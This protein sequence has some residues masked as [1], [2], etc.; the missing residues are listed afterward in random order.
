MRQA[1]PLPFFLILVLLAV[2]IWL[3]S[4]RLGLM[5]ALHIPVSDLALAFTP[6]T[7]AL[8]AV[9]MA[10]GRSGFVRLLVTPFRSFSSSTY[11]G[12]AAAI[13]SP[14]LLYLAAWAVAHL[15]GSPFPLPAGRVAKV[16]MLFPLFMAL[17]LGEELG[18]T[19]HALEA[20]E[21]RCGPLGASLLLALPWW[22]GHLPSMAAIGVDATGMA[23]WLLG[24]M[25]LRVLM[26]ALYHASANRL[27]VVLTFH[28]ML[29]L[30]RL[31]IFP[32][33]GAHYV[34]SYQ[35]TSY[36]LAGACALFV[37]LVT[38]GRLFCDGT[39]RGKD[40]VG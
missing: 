1:S 26:T 23:W 37:V 4:P 20:L 8:C 17:A 18:W 16:I 24:A 19:A 27:L 21:T 32:A 34:P 28:A 15:A 14:W 38:K 3:A 33:Q 36:L 39:A 31:A 11:L 30:A 22:V 29:N 10:D 6:A 9:A 35:T 13:A 12:L 7:A 40:A 5:P 25:A 2:P